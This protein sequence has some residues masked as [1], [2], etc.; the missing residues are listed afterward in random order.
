MYNDILMNG[1][2]RFVVAMSHPSERGRFAEIGVL[3]ELEDLKEVSEQT[4]DQVKYI[5][6]HRVTGRVK[7]HKI[8]NPSAWES[9]ETYL[10]VE[11]TLMDANT[12]GTDT[13][14]ELMD[15][16]V[17]DDVYSRLVEKAKAVYEAPAPKEEANLKLSFK[18]LVKLQ[19]DLEEDV[20]FTRASI[21]TLAVSPGDK[22]EGLWTT[23]RLWQSYSEQRL[24]ARQNELQREFQD[25]L[26]QFLMKE[27][28]VKESELPR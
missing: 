9:R 18:E 15:E 16:F 6:S 7:L 22:D 28:G 3:F 13:K 8:L 11:G 17:D 25:K 27:K 20:R 5:C 14:K 23:I 2:K 26:L 24:V 21:D 10:K 1:S 12:A 19:H 4:N